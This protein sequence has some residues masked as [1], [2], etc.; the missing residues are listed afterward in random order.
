MRL[1]PRA[2]HLK[3]AGLVRVI[4][5]RSLLDAWKEAVRVILSEGHGGTDEG[6]PMRE[7]LDL[8]L[9]ITDPAPE[10]TIARVNPKMA[11]WMHANFTEKAPVPELGNAKS[12][13]TR[14]YDYHGLDQIASVVKK[15]RAKPE[16]KSA[17][18]TTLMPNDDTS[19]VPCVSMLDFKN[20]DGT[21]ILTVTCRSLDFGKK[22]VHNLAELAA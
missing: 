12:Y 7:F 15:L 4:R 8:Y 22:A 19:Y 5:S 20:R 16:T 3:V 6:Q 1:S 11:A 13:A 2:N 10:P 21:L 9:D 17:T 14:L 18:I